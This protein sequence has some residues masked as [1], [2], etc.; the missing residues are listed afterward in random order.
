MPST[1]PTHFVDQFGSSV[2]HLAQRKGSK[3]EP[4][5]QVKTLNGNECTFEQIGSIESVEIT[6]RNADTI[7]S[8]QEHVRRWVGSR[9]FSV[10]KL[11]DWTDDYRALVPLSS[12]Y[13]QSQAYAIG[14]RKDD[15]IVEAFTADAKSD[16]TGSTT[17]SWS[18]SSFTGSNYATDQ[19]YVDHDYDELGQL[20][21][22]GTGM[23]LLKLRAAKRILE[24]RDVDR[25]Q[26]WYFVMTPQQEQDLLSDPNLTTVD[27]MNLK[28]YQSGEMPSFYGFNFVKTTALV[29]GTHGFRECYA[30]T[31]NAMGMA[32]GKNITVEMDRRADKNHSLQIA[33]YFAGNASRLD[34]TEIV[35]VRCEET[36]QTS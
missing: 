18:P 24:M 11:H 4:T 30:Y 32:I 34:E 2:R 25:D 14:R 15:L 16:R 21:S 27:R 29:L 36:P 28:A 3:L 5:V 22:T 10:A 35:Q 8:D 20:A 1:V 7:I 19:L 9:D 23:S 17:V 6:S 13:V 26:P 12:A 33:T 31:G